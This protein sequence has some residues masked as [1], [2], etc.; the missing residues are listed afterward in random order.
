MPGYDGFHGDVECVAPLLHCFNETLR[1][2]HL[3]L[4]I[5]QCFLGLP[6]HAALVLLVGVEHVEKRGRHV[7]VG[8]APFVDGEAHVVVGVRVYNEVGRNLLHVA[9]HGLAHGGPGLGIE[10]QNLALKGCYLAVGEREMLLDAVPTFL[11]EIVVTFVN[12]VIEQHVDGVTFLAFHLQEQAFLEIAGTYAGRV[13]VLQHIEHILDFPFAGIYVVIDG[14][15][16][17]NGIERLAEQTVFIERTN[18]VFKYI[19]LL[20]GKFEFAYLFVEFVVKRSGVAIDLLFIV[21]SLARIVHVFIVGQCVVLANG[22]EHRVEFVLAVFPFRVVFERFF[23][24]RFLSC[25]RL[26]VGMV[27]VHGIVG[28]CAFHGGIVVELHLY[29]LLQFGQRHFQ[30]LHNHHL[31]L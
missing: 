13:K 25:R 19:A 27:V 12:D 18:Q 7:E 16:V 28:R 31:L 2:V 5:E 3:L 6:V 17:F 30:H 26:V 8:Y 21:G 11:E 14:E 9:A 10:F 20:V 1:P 22:V 24:I 23:T 4:G 29:I 15:F